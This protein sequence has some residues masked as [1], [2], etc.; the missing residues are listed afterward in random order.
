MAG[1]FNLLKI[2]STCQPSALLP[3]HY[4]FSPKEGGKDERG[5]ELR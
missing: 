1:V 3:L 4:P 2:N 5:A